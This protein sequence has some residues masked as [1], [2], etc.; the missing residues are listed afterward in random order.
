MKDLKTTAIIIILFGGLISLVPVLFYI[1]QFGDSNLANDTA[2]WG[3]FGDFIGGTINP[4]IGLINLALLIA[5]SVY[6]AKFDSHRQFN[7]YRYEAYIELC[8]KFDTSENTSKGLED[9]KEYMEI[10]LFN[11]QFLF[12]KQSNVIFNSSVNSLI[13][14][15]DKLIPIK[16]Q[17][18]E[19]VE[20]GKIKNIPLPKWLGRDLET[21]LKDIPVTET[22]ESRTI[23]EFS[24]SKKIVLGFIQAVMIESDIR[25]YA[26]N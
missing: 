24:A 26:V 5:I 15:I 4:I 9:L 19:D 3:T 18:E 10:Y 8:R 25:K 16:E 17:Y 21:A 23:K 20:S 14:T 12:P 2:D 7:E 6:V 13:G 11:N 22:D 1:R